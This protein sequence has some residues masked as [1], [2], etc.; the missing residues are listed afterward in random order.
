M[1]K[2]EKRKAIKSDIDRDS[3]IHSE[4]EGREKKSIRRRYRINKTLRDGDV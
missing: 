4:R 3:N 2:R 1:D